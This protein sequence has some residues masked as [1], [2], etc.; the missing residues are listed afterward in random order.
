MSVAACA[1]L[2]AAGD[3][4]RARAALAA[5]AGPRARLWP[6]YAYN[7]ELA[8]AAW[9]PAEPALADLRLAWWGEAVADAARGGPPRAHAVAAP[10]AALLGTLGHLAGPLAAMAA[11]RRREAWRE[12]FADEAALA[13]HLDATAAG[14]MWCAAV[15]LGAPPSAEAVVRA[16]GRAAGLAAW[17]AAAPA[18][19]ARGL[20][21]LPSD[22]PDRIAA[23]AREGLAGLARARAGRAAVPRGVAAA[24]LVAAP[25]GTILARAARAPARVA[26][27]TLAP[28]EFRLRLALLAGA[29]SGR[30]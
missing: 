5:P 8:R 26:A 15:A 10:L 14:L 16:L 20:R 29:L 18:L 22:A 6:L 28:P 12:P 13:A 23:L 11:A 4:L 24:L 21:P 1:A 3:P 2:V 25:A 27:G 17:L 19:A 7:L 30:W 9:G